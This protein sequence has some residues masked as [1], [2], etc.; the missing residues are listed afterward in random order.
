[1]MQIRTNYDIP[2]ASEQI[3]EFISEFIDLNTIILC[4]G[5]DKVK[6]DSLAPLVGTL[7]SQERYPLKIYGKLGDTVNALNLENS[8]EEIT[9]AHPHSNIVAVDACLALDI[10]DIIARDYPL[11]PGAALNKPLPQVGT[12]CILGAT[13]VD[14][15]NHEIDSSVLYKMA[16]VIV[17]ALQISYKKAKERI[18]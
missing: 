5:S 16:E 1:M 11:S 14:S 8:L 13:M 12:A 9:S 15:I 7:L 6:G 4:I 3:A 2:F 17:K 18:Q 10:G